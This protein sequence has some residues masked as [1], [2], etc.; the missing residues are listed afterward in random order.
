MVNFEK[1]DNIDIV[2]FNVAKINALNTE[3]IK[4]QVEQIIS[5]PNSRII[6]DLQGVEY[7]DS[8]GFGCLL[9]CLRKSRNNYGSLKISNPEPP[10]NAAIETLHLQTIFEIFDDIDECIRSFR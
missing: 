4:E 7:I 1:R 3:E 8:S 5:Q 6:I 2:T 10:V 9:S